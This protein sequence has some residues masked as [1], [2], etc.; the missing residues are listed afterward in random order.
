MPDTTTNSTHNIVNGITRGVMAAGGGA[1]MAASHDELL[2]L[3][4]ALATVLSLVWSIWEKLQSRKAAAPPVAPPPA[5]LPLP[6]LLAGLVAFVVAGCANPRMVAYKSL[7]AVGQT[8]AAAMSAAATL[9]V[10]GKLTDAGWAQIAAAHDKFAPAYAAALRTAQLDY[11]QPASATLVAL[12]QEVL[13]LA[14]LY[15]PHQ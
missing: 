1:T 11:T 12:A 7:A 4:G 9:K 3:V 13:D 14:M 6:L 2:Q 5:G 10:Q 8:E 15:A